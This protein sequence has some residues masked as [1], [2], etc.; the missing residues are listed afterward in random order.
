MKYLLKKITGCLVEKDT[1]IKSPILFNNKKAERDTNRKFAPQ[2]NEL[3]DLI[4]DSF[5][6]VHFNSNYIFRTD[7]DINQIEKILVFL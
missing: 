7:I 1:F 3:L 4:K 5:E 6:V 2:A